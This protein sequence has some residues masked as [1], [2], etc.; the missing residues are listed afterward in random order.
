MLQ[1][2]VNEQMAKEKLIADVARRQSRLD[3][4]QLTIRYDIA[5]KQLDSNGESMPARLAVQQSDVDQARAIVALK[6]RQ[7]SDLQVRAGSPGVLQVVPVEVGQQVLPGSNLARVANPSLLK[8][9]VKIPETQARDVQIGQKASVDTRVGIVTGRVVRVDPSVQNGTV[10]VDVA[11]DGAL[12]KGAR[13]DLTI[14]GTIELERLDNVVFVGVPA[15]AQ[16]NTTTNLFRVSPD[17]SAT[18]V[19]VR[20]GRAS[21]SAIEV[22]EGLSPGDQV[23]LSDTSRVSEYNRIRLE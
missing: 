19:P 18:R 15:I 6:R 23:I 11:F 7:V 4:D 5:K 2:D 9:E 3:A 20:L 10:T 22:L 12:P 14:D 8:A 21:V 13:P 16:E 17:G 1:A